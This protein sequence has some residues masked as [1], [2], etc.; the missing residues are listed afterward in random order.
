M[1]PFSEEDY[2]Y[3][4]GSEVALEDEQVNPEEAC[5]RHDIIEDGEAPLSRFGVHGRGNYRKETGDRNTG[6]R[7]RYGDG[8][9]LGISRDK[10]SLRVDNVC[11]TLGGMPT[12]RVKLV[13][14]MSLRKSICYLDLFMP[15]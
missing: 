12:C 1:E 5:C 14:Y 2:K 3:S 4:R 13:R 9:P 10:L 11:D 7:D 15:T 6:D 8:E